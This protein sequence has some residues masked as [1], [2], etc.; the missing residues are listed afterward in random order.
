MR[1]GTRSRL[2]TTILA[3]LTSTAC[4]RA[5]VT[6]W[7]QVNAPDG[8]FSV[9]LP[10]NPVKEDTPTKSVTGGSFV[11][12]SF[13]TR[14]SKSAGNAGYACAWW[15]DPTL[16]ARTPEQILDSLRDNALSSIQGELLEEKRL[17][18][19]GHPGRDI[20]AVVRGHDYD[21]R[22]LVVGNRVYSLMIVGEKRDSKN[23]AKFFDSLILH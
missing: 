5:P 10:G 8:T 20:R 11:S 21:N 18:I 17:T 15:E 3:L 2:A 4:N 6:E 16:K 12:H 1:L 14:S 9:T 22:I 19:Q 23:V 13:K 7:H